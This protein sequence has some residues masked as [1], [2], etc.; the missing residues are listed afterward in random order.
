MDLSN[1]FCSSS[2]FIITHGRELHGLIR[3][4]VKNHILQDVLNVTSCIHVIFSDIF[5][6]GGK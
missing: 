2:V 4:C 6:R 1:C 5:I 3:S